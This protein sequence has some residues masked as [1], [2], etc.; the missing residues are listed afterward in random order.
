LVTCVRMDTRT[1]VLEVA[2]RLLDASPNRDVATRDVCAA[3]GIT[4]PALYRLFGDKTGLLR[5]VV[6]FG[7]DRYLATKRD[8]PVSDDPLQDLRD[9]WDTHTRFALEHPA[10]Y[11]LMFSPAFDEVP[12]SAGEALRIL[13]GVLERCAAAGLLAA[14]VELAAETIM[15]ANIGLALSLVTQPGRYTHPELSRT[16]RDATHRQL[17]TP[18]AMG[19]GQR[20]QPGLAAAA[21]RLDAQLAQDDDA[22]LSDAEAVLLREWLRRLR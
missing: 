17:L 4:P 3:A 18:E 15:A 2:E 14:D 12:D 8:A 13:R 16:V 5:A 1:H 6:D 20:P 22:P 19:D 21:R 10:V 7:F 9:G 11:R